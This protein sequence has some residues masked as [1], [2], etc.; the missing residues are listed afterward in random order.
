MHY[1]SIRDPHNA[2]RSEHGRI[3]VT[4]V[5]LLRQLPYTEVLLGDSFAFQYAKIAV[6]K[7]PQIRGPADHF[8]KASHHRHAV[9]TFV[10]IRP[11]CQAASAHH[12]RCRPSP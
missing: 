12:R 8:P 9:G 11:C 4:P 5:L 3:A 2:F 7:A 6:V 10:R 1:S